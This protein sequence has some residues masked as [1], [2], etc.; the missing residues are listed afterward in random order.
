[1]HDPTVEICSELREFAEPQRA[2]VHQRFFKT[3]RGEYG[4]GDKFL[5]IR[6]PHIRKLAGKFRGLSM[7]DTEKLLHSQWHEERLFALLVM[8]D[9][10]GRNKDE[11]QENIYDLYMSSTRWINN[12]DLVDISAPKILGDYLLDKDRSILYKMARSKD[13]WK[14]RIAIVSTFAFIRAGQFKETMEIAELLLGDRHDLIHK[15]VGWMLREVGKRNLREEEKFL[16]K[17]ASV[18][19][20]TMLRYAIEKFET[21]KRLRYMRRS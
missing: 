8:V 2:R 10:F 13:L 4:E 5:G 21:E 6:V 3:G 9:S 17:H 20:R 7:T 19:P 16:K 1:M 14:K 15:A 11:L 18:M 12:W